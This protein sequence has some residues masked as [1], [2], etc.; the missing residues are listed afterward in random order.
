MLLTQ[1]IPARRSGMWTLKLFVE[2][3][4]VYSPKIMLELVKLFLATLVLH[5][6]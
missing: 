3:I 4:T 5:P 1:P 2:A 6:V